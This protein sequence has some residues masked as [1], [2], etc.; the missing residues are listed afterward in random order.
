[1]GS[2]AEAQLVDAAIRRHLEDFRVDEI[3]VYEPCGEG[4]H[5]FVS[6]RKT[7]LTTLEA[8]RRL[9]RALGVDPRSAGFAG[10]KDR[11]AITTQTA[12]FALPLDRDVPECAPIEGIE[13]LSMRRHRH[14]LRTG[15]LRGN[16]FALI[17]RDIDASVRATVDGALTELCEHGVPNAFGRQRFGR[18]GDNAAQALEWLRGNRKP[19]RGRKEQRL[20]FSALQSDLFNQVLERRERDGSWNTV[21]GGDLAHKISGGL[22]Q[23]PLEGSELDACI[24]RAQ[25]GEICATG[26]MFGARM[27]WPT[28]APAELEREVLAHAG[29]E[30]EL[31]A[32]HRALGEGTRRPLRLSVDELEWS[33][34]EGETFLTVRFVLP[35]GGYATTVLSRAF[36]LHDPQAGT[37]PPSAKER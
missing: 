29:V 32:A 2:Q 1:M 20:M 10:M 27:R 5:L 24:E 14:K 23:V 13:I 26:P 8:V 30:E 35:K 18:E 6:F 3:P 9:A 15:Q 7:D 12:S 33:W 16:R 11:R 34:D 19:P 4:E 22:F 17:L 37:P 31:F 36:R 25:R 21:L 28:G